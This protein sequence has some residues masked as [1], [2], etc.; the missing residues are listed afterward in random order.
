[1]KTLVIIQARMSSTRL[2]GKVML[3]VLGRPLLF[4]LLERLR[5]VRSADGVVVAMPKDE[6]SQP[7]IE[8]CRAFPAHY[9]LGSEDDVLG[10]FHGAAKEFEADVIVRITADCPLIDPDVIEL[11]LRH[12]LDARGRFD[13]VANWSF[14]PVTRVATH[15]FPLGMSVEVF[16]F[17]VLTQSQRHAKIGPEREHVTPYLYVV[18]GRF[19]VGHVER[20]ESLA[21]HRWTVDTSEDF[22]LIRRILEALYP[23]RQDFRTDEILD[24]LA[25]HPE[26]CL[27]N[28]HIPPPSLDSQKEGLR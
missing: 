19:S 13:Y 21:H 17:S 20:S 25:C 18:P 12:Y 4:Y 11:T 8:L 26:W 9:F 14:D 22:E 2:P 6:R 7:M 5:H 27:L 23:V 1:M 16:S 10:R 24:L 28:A 15:T 3:P